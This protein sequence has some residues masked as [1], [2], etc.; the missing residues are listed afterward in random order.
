MVTSQCSM[1]ALEKKGAVEHKLN[2]S[3]EGPH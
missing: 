3:G 1:C 2:L